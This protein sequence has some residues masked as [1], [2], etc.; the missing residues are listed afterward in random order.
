MKHSS[1]SHRWY[2]P[3]YGTYQCEPSVVRSSLWDISVRA[4]GLRSSLWDISVRAIGGTLILMG[5]I[6][7]SHRCDT[8]ILMGHIS[9]SHRWYAPPYGT[10]QCEPSVVRASVNVLMSDVSHIE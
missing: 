6:S 4:T 3:P 10:Y 2:A 9:A 7:A 5:Y 1:A 8:L